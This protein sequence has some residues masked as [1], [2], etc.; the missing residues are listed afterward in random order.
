MT[1][2]RL[3]NAVICHYARGHRM[4]IGGQTIN[5][6]DGIFWWVVLYNV[7]RDPDEYFFG[8]NL[9]MTDRKSSNW[10]RDASI[11]KWIV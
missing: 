10:S 6:N 5:G 4:Y 2:E 11:Y 7:N 9:S 3:Y 8:Y 1:I